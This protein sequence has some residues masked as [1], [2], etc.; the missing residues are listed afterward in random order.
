[1]TT[2]Q[3]QGFCNINSESN[4][5]T[6]TELRSVAT[7]NDDSNCI[8][9]QSQEEPIK[10]D[11]KIKRCDAKIKKLRNRI[12]KQ[13]ESIIK[14]KIKERKTLKYIIMNC[15]REM[16][17]KSHIVSDKLV[18]IKNK[19][20]DS[21]FNDDENSRHFLGAQMFYNTNTNLFRPTYNG[22]RCT[23]IKEE[24]F[25]IARE[26]INKIR[27]KMEYNKKKKS[28]DKNYFDSSENDSDASF[29]T[30]KSTISCEAKDSG[31]KKD[32]YN[33]GNKKRR[34]KSIKK[35]K[36]IKKDFS[37]NKKEIKN[38]EENEGKESGLIKGVEESSV[39]KDV[40]R[41]EKR[42]EKRKNLDNENKK[43]MKIN[44]KSNGKRKNRDNDNTKKI[45]LNK[46]NKNNESSEF[47]DCDGPIQKDPKLLMYPNDISVV[48]IPKEYL[49]IK[50]ITPEICESL[51]RKNP[52]E[53]VPR[54]IFKSDVP[55]DEYEKYYSKENVERIHYKLDKEREEEKIK[56]GKYNTLEYF[57]ECQERIKLKKAEAECKERANEIQISNN[58]SFN[59]NLIDA[60]REA[61]EVMQNYLKCY[62]NELK[63]NKINNIK[64]ERHENN[65]ETNNDK[66]IND[67]TNRVLN[68]E[69]NI[70]SFNDNKNDLINS[71]NDLV[72][73]R[74]DKK[75]NSF[76]KS[77]DNEKI[78]TQLK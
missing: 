38:G 76:S 52:G 56:Y 61:E 34:N 4:S 69:K 27:N 11:E 6:N 25:V 48:Y 3:V 49:G 9:S 39:I 40:K 43:K 10:I 73:N 30:A 37:D 12:E 78:E 68:N 31:D 7:K 28:A 32:D 44:K 64:S 47:Y 19:V 62:E 65:P 36:R 57:N 51:R 46:R 21:F 70:D 1:M 41:M 58:N 77:S 53:E 23:K 45:K 20:I 60:E 16:A 29:Y 15:A 66:N 2:F 59:K 17:S 33:F 35:V 13:T 8:T 5:E 55:I 63:Q 75:T 14:K 26:H 42:V 24:D 67:D 72:N 71:N 74:D 54:F 50:K 18:E 22:K